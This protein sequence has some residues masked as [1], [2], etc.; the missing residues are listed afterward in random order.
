MCF[1][2][3][4]RAQTRVTVIFLFLFPFSVGMRECQWGAEDEATVKDARA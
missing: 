4:N 2:N 1:I 3:I